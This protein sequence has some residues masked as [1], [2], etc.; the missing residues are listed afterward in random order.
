MFKF[1]LK[2]ILHIIPIFILLSIV[3][4][5][6]ADAMPGDALL[7]YLR[8]SGRGNDTEPPS[9]FQILKIRKNLG[10][11]DP[12]HIRYF[13][14]AKEFVKGNFGNSIITRRPVK[15]TVKPLILNS[16]L[17]N[18][19]S[20]ILIFLISIPIGV[21]SA[22]KKYGVFDNLFTTITLLSISIPAIFICLFLMYFIAVPSEWLP[23][24]GMR[25]VINA[26]KG[27]PT[28]FAE[29]I[30]VL[31]HL[32]LPVTASVFLG[33]GSVT[34]YVRS[35]VIDVI[36]QDYIRT[37]RAKGL[38]DRVVIYKHA[39]RNALI[40]I[41]TLMGLMIPTLFIGNIIIEAVFAWPG[42][43]KNLIESVINRDVPMIL[44][45]NL[46]FAIVAILGNLLADL[47]YGIVDP[48]IRVGE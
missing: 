38:S 32:I 21:K 27:Y 48:R 36:N 34:K 43:G 25:N 9:P 17:L 14:W 3:I 30:D 16:F 10:L 22:T 7:A 41:I 26:A 2:R 19:T 4:F 6:I 20:A 33:F 47:L 12:F 29:A 8:G 44:L 15:D 23:L 35:S 40:P 11:D 46:F 28:K 39:F 42:I 45:A 5:F 1:A 31:K 24:T 18:F 37:A 13:T